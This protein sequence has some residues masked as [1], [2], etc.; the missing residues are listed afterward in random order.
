MPAILGQC[1]VIAGRGGG[2][3]VDKAEGGGAAWGYEGGGGWGSTYGFKHHAYV[4]LV[5]AEKMRTANSHALPPHQ[6]GVFLGLLNRKPIHGS[7][8]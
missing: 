1:H 4:L 3:V 2:G 8:V 6:E 7:A 5:L